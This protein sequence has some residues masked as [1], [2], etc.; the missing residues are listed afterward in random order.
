MTNLT[1]LTCDSMVIGS[2]TLPIPTVQTLTGNGA[3]TI[4]HG[5][6]LLNK[7]S[8]I[9]AT[10]ANPIVGTD[11]YKRLLIVSVTAQT[12]TVTSAEGFG[13]PTADCIKEGED[14]ATYAG[15]IGDALSLIAFNG[16]WYIQGKH[17]ITV[18]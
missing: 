9:A 16:A 5:I 10:I 2:Y 1:D 12:H 11:D 18:A 13:N 7:S 17:G 15:A 4:K 8:A 14:V 3:I 6:V